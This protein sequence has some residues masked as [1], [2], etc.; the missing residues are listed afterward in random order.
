MR[1]IFCVVIAAFFATAC[2]PT[3]YTHIEKIDDGYLLTR[4]KAN[5]I[6]VK[7]QIWKC[8]PETPTTFKCTPGGVR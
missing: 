3:Q 4:N 1:K 7:G 2:F 5:F 6:K 8:T